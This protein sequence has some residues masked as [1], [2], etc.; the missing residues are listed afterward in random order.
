MIFVVLG[1]QKFQFNRLL[2]QMDSLI[3]R[4][5]LA[6]DVFAQTGNSG[7]VPRHYPYAP[8]LD[9]EPFEE[10]MAAC[11]LLIAHGGVGT[12][13][14]GLSKYKPVIVCPRRKAFGEHVDD[15]QFEIARAFSQRKH[16][17][18]CDDMDKLSDAI[19]QSREFCFEPYRSHREQVIRTIEAFLSA[20]DGGGS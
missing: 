12:I 8:F 14:S 20:V 16:A 2:A 13:I 3:E 10:K 7:Y 5:L 18:L 9:K 6:E 11:G 1:T 19:A 4:N 17:L 15:H